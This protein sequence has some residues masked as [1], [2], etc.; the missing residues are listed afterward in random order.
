MVP[1]SCI[2]YPGRGR[3]SRQASNSCSV[4][5]S[6]LEV[7]LSQV[8]SRLSSNSKPHCR[9]PEFHQGMPR[10]AGG[11][12]KRAAPSCGEQV[13]G[14]EI[15]GIIAHGHCGG[16]AGDAASHSGL[17][18]CRGARVSELE[19]GKGRCLACDIGGEFSVGFM[20]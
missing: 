18:Y 16:I 1:Y 9:L 7:S 5:G 14:N 6:A 4:A 15:T 17:N 8:E 10:Y 2:G 3:V 11:P 19:M 13:W 12:G 20:L